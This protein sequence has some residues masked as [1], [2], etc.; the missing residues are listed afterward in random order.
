MEGTLQNFYNKLGEIAE[1]FN[2]NY[3]KNAVLAPYTTMKIGGTCDILVK[4]NSDDCL[5]SLISF[6]RKNTISY[7][8][9]GMGSNVL[10]S[11]KGISGAV[12]LLGKDMSEI[13]VFGTTITAK[14]GAKLIDVCKKA[15]EHSLTGLE[16]AYGI[17]GS[18]GGALFM[19]AGAYGGEMKDIV[20]SCNFIEN[21]EVNSMNI[22]QMQLAYRKS[23][24]SL[25]NAYVTSVSFQLQKGNHA[26][27]KTKMDD[28]MQRRIDKQPLEYPSAGSTFKRPIGD[29]A[30]R[31]IE[32]C[33]LKGSTYG[34][35]EVSTKHS[36]FVIN[37]DHATFDDVLGVVKNVK[38][39]VNEQTGVMLECEMLIWE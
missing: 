4:I 31:L 17:P 9:L 30:S 22:E 38:Q 34:G 3:E 8:I 37:K 1:S 2:A 15:L 18:V 32:S 19:N 5:L 16:F 6:C 25:N 13:T 20:S 11:D 27:I 10:I 24:F 28:I 36:G 39:K 26:E 7:R 21:G 29:F 12:F 33:G 14:A 35:A 23:Y